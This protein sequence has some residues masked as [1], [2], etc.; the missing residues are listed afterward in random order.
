MSGKKWAATATV[1]VLGALAAGCGGDPPPRPSAEVLAVD[2][3]V[4]KLRASGSYRTE[5]EVR[6]DIGLAT[7]RQAGEGRY[8][9][10]D[11]PA[12]AIVAVREDND[13]KKVADVE[14]VIVDG[15]HYLRSTDVATPAKRPWVRMAGNERAISRYGT[16]VAWFP[17]A[18]P[19]FWL[20]LRWT[21][22]PNESKRFANLGTEQVGEIS[23]TRYSGGC[24]LALQCFGP[25]IRGWFDRSAADT[26]Y[27]TIDVWIDGDGQLRKYSVRSSVNLGQ[28]YYPFNASAV[29]HDHGAPVRVDPPPPAQVVEAAA[30]PSP[31]GRPT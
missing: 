9:L 21:T 27:F 20:D 12:S 8:R 1:V 7:V 10:A 3:A 18:D 11:G 31:S 23:T 25:Q 22:T 19:L 2:A 5:F 14:L 15:V 30:I 24:K 4:A 26:G 29:I 6:I 13:R 17:P 16:G 28:D